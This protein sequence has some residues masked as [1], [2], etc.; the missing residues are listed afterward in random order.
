VA[1]YDNQYADLRHFPQIHVSHVTF[2]FGFL[3]PNAIGSLICDKAQVLRTKHIA[4]F[5][6]VNGWTSPRGQAPLGLQFQQTLSFDCD[7][8]KARHLAVVRSL[9]TLT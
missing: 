9:V 1:F 2:R 3:G 8:I 7:G 6:G 4:D 5:D